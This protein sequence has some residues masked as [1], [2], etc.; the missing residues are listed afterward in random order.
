M[1]FP[2]DVREFWNNR[3][4][5]L[6]LIIGLGSALM[7]DANAS[8]QFNGSNSKAVLDGVYLDGAVHSDY[9]LEMWIK[10]AALGGT[11]IAKTLA[12]KEWSLDTSTD[13][14][15]MLRG[16][17]PN[18]YW[19]TFTGVGS[20]KPNVWQ[21][22]SCGVTK[23]EAT[24][25]VNGK[26]VGTAPV[27]DPLDFAAS[28][29]GGPSLDSTMSIGYTDS[30]TTP[31]YNFFNGL[32]YGI[33][34]W[35]RALEV[36]E[37]Q[38]IATTGVP[39]S[40]SG[41]GNSV[42]LNEG[43]GN[44]IAD[45]LTALRGRVL[46]AQWSA[47]APSFKS[48]ADLTTGLVAHYPFNGNAND[49]SGNAVNGTVHGGVLTTNRFGHSNS[50]YHFSGG[51]Y[52]DIPLDCSSM[53]PLTYSLWFNQDSPAQWPAQALIWTGTFDAAGQDL[54]IRNPVNDFWVSHQPNSNF[55]TGVVVKQHTW[56]HVAVT[57]S[58][59]VILYVNGIKVFETTYPAQP[60]RRSSITRLGR[61][62]DFY[63]YS[64]EGTIDDVRIYSRA[65]TSLEV[66]RLFATESQ[67][68]ASTGPTIVQHP[69]SQTVNAGANVTFSVGLKTAGTYNYQWQINEQNIPGANQ[70]TL[71][72]SNVAAGTSRY[73]AIVSNTSGTVISDTATLTVNPTP[74]PSIVTQP[75]SQTVTEGASLSLSVVANGSGALSYQ[76]QLN[77]QNLSGANQAI[78]TLNGV[79]VSS[80]GIYRVVVS[81]PSGVTISDEATLTVNANPPPSILTHPSSQ[82]PAEGSQLVLSVTAT[83]PGTLSY[84]WQVDQQNIPRA[85]ESTFVIS[86]IR[87][88]S[89][90]R[91]RVLVMNQY[92]TATSTEAIIRVIVLDSDNDGLSDFEE[93]L[94][95]TDPRTSDTDRDGL[96]DAV[97]V[98]NYNTNPLISDTDGDGYSDGIEVSLGG[99]P[100]NRSIV[101]AGALAVFRAVDVEFYTLSRNH[102]VRLSN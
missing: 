11:L 40:T 62:Q 10:P 20:I 36:G 6:M 65:L 51:Q 102:A 24:F 7:P 96:T 84:Q 75:K 67:S 77:Q 98:R 93:L 99:N 3:V 37:V 49:A 82:A 52:I 92:G 72:L 50:A 60:T 26:L 59:K 34:V 101:P 57:Y 19:G 88:G 95:G 15:V 79:K 54:G 100:T 74:P 1:M 46:T 47:D 25:F 14:G 8:L 80:S 32:I 17:W 5:T 39:T 58:D 22:I 38:A 27:H 61:N 18:F 53:K 64:F 23:G 9:T 29:I 81:S 68:D 86:G 33:R 73:R 45:S 90:G 70:T 56:T 12:W 43:S 30:G 76:W 97:E 55:T 89:N 69:V 63:N 4:S 35:N 31:D 71:T 28:T 42:M 85:N 48:A 66:E 2:S 21:H 91:Y 94:L 83:G 13:G 41:L 16:A 44:V 78:L 87:P